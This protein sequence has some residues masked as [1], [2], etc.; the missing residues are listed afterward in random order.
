MSEGKFLPSQV[1]KEENVHHFMSAGATEKS[2]KCI[3]VLA[4]HLQRTHRSAFLIVEV[5]W[6]TQGVLFDISLCLL[7][8]RFHKGL[9]ML[10]YICPLY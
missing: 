9:L 4:A 2:L 7:E 8:S 3:D 10:V 1:V 5:C 6:E